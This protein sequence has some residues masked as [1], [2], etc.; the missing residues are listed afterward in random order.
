MLYSQGGK[1]RPVLI[2]PK[3]HIYPLS[4]HVAFFYK[5]SFISIRLRGFSRIPEHIR[6]PTTPARCYEEI[7]SAELP[8]GPLGFDNDGEVQTSVDVNSPSISSPR[9]VQMKDVAVFRPDVAVCR[10][11]FGTQSEESNSSLHTIQRLLYLV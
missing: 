6:Y 2:Y 3:R 7:S 1:E 4:L 5:P 9:T 10:E 11:R 8:S